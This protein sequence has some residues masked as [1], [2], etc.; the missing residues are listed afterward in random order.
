MLK[1]LT[2]VILMI[3]IVPHPV[4]AQGSEDRVISIVDS[5]MSDERKV[6][7]IRAVLEREGRKPQIIIQQPKNKWTE[8][9]RLLPAIITA[10]VLAKN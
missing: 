4:I 2:L 6:E 1:I 3:M 7:A 10:V 8:L 9:L 5:D